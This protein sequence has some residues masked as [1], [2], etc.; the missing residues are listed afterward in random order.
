[1]IIS[2]VNET[3]SA[4]CLVIIYTHNM[5]TIALIVI[6]IIMVNLVYLATWCAIY[7]LNYY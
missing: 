3:F 5:Y 7:L 1:M 6:I 2:F 4:V